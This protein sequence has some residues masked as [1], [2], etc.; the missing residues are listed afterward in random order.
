MKWTRRDAHT[1]MAEDF[2]YCTSKYQLTNVELFTFHLLVFLGSHVSSVDA[3]FER[4]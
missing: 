1:G 4:F 3:L 2:S